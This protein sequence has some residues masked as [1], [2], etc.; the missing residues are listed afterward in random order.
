MK[1]NEAIKSKDFD[2]AITYYSRSLELD[3]N[4]YQAFGNRALAYFKKKCS[5]GIT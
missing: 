3:P 5:C 4:M 2:E 1:G